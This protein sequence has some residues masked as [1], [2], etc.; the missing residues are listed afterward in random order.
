MADVTFTAASVIKGANA[1]TVQGVSGET[2]TAGLAV[3]LKAADNRYWIA[4]C[5]TSAATAAMVG[6][7]LNGASAGQDITIQTAGDMTCDGLSLSVTG[8]VPTYVLSA[9]GKIAPASDLAA[10][11]YITIVGAALSTTSLRLRIGATGVQATA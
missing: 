8:S 6:F 10:S 9:A 11:D 5:E 1:I 2:I 4:H 3:Y 7:A